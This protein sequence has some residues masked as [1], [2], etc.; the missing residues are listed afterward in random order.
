MDQVRNEAGMEDWMFNN[1]VIPWGTKTMDEVLA[2]PNVVPYHK[3]YTQNA[4]NNV[5][6]GTDW[7]SL[8]TREGSIAQHNVTITRHKSHQISPLGQ[9]LQLQ[10]HHCQCRFQTVFGKG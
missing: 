4:I 6:K 1:H 2:D 10:R 3:L 5:G 8:V 9:L 7:L